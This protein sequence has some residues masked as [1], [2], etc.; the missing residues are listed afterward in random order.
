MIIYFESAVNKHDDGTSPWLVD[1]SRLTFFFFF[2]QMQHPLD[3]LQNDEYCLL[4]E[5]F[6]FLRNSFLFID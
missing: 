2:D 4:T 6:F 3:I 5:K 1:L